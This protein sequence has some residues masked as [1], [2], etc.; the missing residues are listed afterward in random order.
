MAMFRFHASTN[1][2]DRKN[3]FELREEVELGCR[4]REGH[5]KI[6]YANDELRKEKPSGG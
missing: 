5:E 6:E 2:R 3:N 1:E 4:R